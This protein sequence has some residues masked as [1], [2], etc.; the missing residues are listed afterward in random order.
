MDSVTPPTQPWPLKCQI[1]DLTHSSLRHATAPLSLDPPSRAVDGSTRCNRYS[2][3]R[4]VA[5]QYI[6]GT[7][8]SQRA[9]A[10]DP[11]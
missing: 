1:H 5:R 11:R 4:C 6:K 10:R 9:V 2:R 8:E 7:G 3:V